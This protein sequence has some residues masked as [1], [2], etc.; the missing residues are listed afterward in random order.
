[1]ARWRPALSQYQWIEWMA[2]KI[3]NRTRSSDS[4]LGDRDC[5]GNNAQGKLHGRQKRRLVRD[6]ESLMQ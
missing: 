5:T 6:V 4:S 3:S 2:T 1:V